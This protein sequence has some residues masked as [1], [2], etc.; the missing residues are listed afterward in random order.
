MRSMIS[1]HLMTVSGSFPRL[2]SFAIVR[3]RSVS[4]W[5]SRT[6]I[7]LQASRITSG[8]FFMSRRPPTASRIFSDCATST[9]RQLARVGEH[10]VDVVEPEPLRGGVGEVEHVVDAREQLVDLCAVERGDELGMQ[11]GERPVGDVVGAVLDVLD[12][13][14]LRRARS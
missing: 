4:A 3:R 14:H 2:K 10:L 5:F 11:A 13:L 8:F 12:R 1:F 7:S 9:A 6:L